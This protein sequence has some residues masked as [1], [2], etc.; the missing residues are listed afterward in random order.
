MLTGGTPAYMSHEKARGEGHRLDGRSD[1]FALGVMLYEMLTTR[2]PFRG[3]S[4]METLHQ[5][6]SQDPRPAL[7]KKARLDKKLDACTNNLWLPDVQK[8]K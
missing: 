3:R 2:R 1:V 4:V 6:M 8:G 5:V 7:H